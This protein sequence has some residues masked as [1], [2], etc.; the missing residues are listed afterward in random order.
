VAAQAEAGEGASRAGRQ[1]ERPDERLVAIDPARPDP[2]VL[3]RAAAVLRAGGLVAFPTETVYGLGANALDDAAVR[4]IYAAKGRDAADP[5]IVHLAGQEDL[6]AVAVEPPAV[7]ALLG[8]RFWPGP[9]TLVLRKSGRVPDSATAGLPS[10]AVRVPRHPVAQGL[11]RA[12]GVPVAAPS[13]NTFT[14]T[15][16]TTAGHVLEDLGGRVDL[17]LDGGPAPIG[18]ESTVLAVAPDGALRLLRPGAV[19]VEAVDAA[20]AAAGLPPVAPRAPDGAPAPA[21]GAAAPAPGQMLK[22][23]APRARL[24]Y[25]RGE[26]DGARTALLA[27]AGAALARGERV[28]LLLYDEDAALPAA[29]G[30]AGAT[31]PEG[32]AGDAGRVQS[33]ALGPASDP[34]GVA[35]SLFAAMRRLD[36][37]GVDVILA[38]GLPQSGLGLAIDDRLT[39]AAGSRVLPAGPD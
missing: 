38:R 36:A 27:A 33:A 1:H 9:L 26:G 28:G 14:R 30:A 2:A 31:P 24:L 5:L 8:A 21:P 12:A 17:I 19:P 16:A 35:R 34:A 13:A 6:P 10:V 29:L 3:A 20:L 11:L 22:H 18:I 15:S 4:R 37:L 39:R 23:Y 7:V 32:G 25:V